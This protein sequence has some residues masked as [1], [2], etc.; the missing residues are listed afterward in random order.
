M[1]LTDGYALMKLLLV[2]WL[3]QY[4]GTEAKDND[5]KDEKP[6]AII[7]IGPHK[8]A[9]TT[10]QNMMISARGVERMQKMNMYTY[11]PEL[12]ED[13]QNK[14][15]QFVEDL[16]HHH[17]DSSSN[18]AP[19]MWEFFNQSRLQRRNIILSTEDL[20]CLS[21]HQIG[22]LQ[23]M[24]GGFE[25]TVIVVYREYIS[26]L[27]SFHSQRNKVSSTVGGASLKTIMDTGIK[28]DSFNFTITTPPYTYLTIST[29]P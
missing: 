20:V 6:K 18:S 15:V 16:Y 24:L 7:H 21:L 5:G 26:H 12:E 23:Q 14:V 27:V 28:T 22:R 17:P 9:T 25:V 3:S 8:T 11:H 2:L 10:I 4:T 29:T 13:S 19:Q 1:G